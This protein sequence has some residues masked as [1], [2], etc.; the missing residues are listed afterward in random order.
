MMAHSDLVWLRRDL[1]LIDNE[2]FACQPRAESMLCVYVLEPE[3]LDPESEALDGGQWAFLWES[4]MALRGNLLTRGSDLLVCVGNP[5]RLLPELLRRIGATRLITHDMAGENEQRTTQALR[6]ALGAERLTVLSDSPLFAALS[7][8]ESNDDMSFG[9]FVERTR[10]SALLEPLTVVLPVSLPPWPEDG[11]RGLP[12]MDSLSLPRQSAAD[13]NALS[14]GEDAAQARLQRLAAGDEPW[15]LVTSRELLRWRDLG[16]LS[17]RQLYAASRDVESDAGTSDPREA[18]VGKAARQFLR[19][20]LL[21]GEYQQWRGEA[22]AATSAGK[23]DPIGGSEGRYP[24][25]GDASCDH[26]ED[27]RNPLCAGETPLP[28]DNGL[29]ATQDGSLHTPTPSRDKRERPATDS[30]YDRY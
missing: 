1:R 22:N 28:A 14:G 12:S 23:V 3:W 9:A 24:A 16:C 17:R 2:L 20:E 6:E 10:D 8:P 27:S 7:R 19:H 18:A 4:L 11:P 15:S 25:P 5:A 21:W 29:D 30:W 26:L 13:V